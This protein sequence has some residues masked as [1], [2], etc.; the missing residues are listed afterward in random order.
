MLGG[1]LG[2]LSQG[3]G[4]RSGRRASLAREGER[5]LFLFGLFDLDLIVAL[6]RRVLLD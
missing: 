6:G 2:G 1:G 4:H 5:E 3:G